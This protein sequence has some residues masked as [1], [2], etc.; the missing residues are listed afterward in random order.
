LIRLI[1][2]NLSVGIQFDALIVPVENK[3]TSL[4]NNTTSKPIFLILRTDDSVVATRRA[5]STMIVVKVLTHI[6]NELEFFVDAANG[7]V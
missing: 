6:S 5:S 2:V 4:L 7:G 1:G 3:G